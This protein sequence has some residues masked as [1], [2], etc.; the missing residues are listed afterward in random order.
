MPLVKICPSCNERM[1]PLGHERLS[2]ERLWSAIR[3][4]RV[5]KCPHCGTAYKASRGYWYMAHIGGLVTGIGALGLLGLTVDLISPTYTLRKWAS[6]SRWPPS[7]N[8][9]STVE[10]LGA[11]VGDGRNGASTP[12][13]ASRPCCAPLRLVLACPPLAN[14]RNLAR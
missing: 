4:P 2:R 14:A 6:N 9:R 8:P 13:L 3:K 5:V 1:L 7:V 11:A 12:I 10:S